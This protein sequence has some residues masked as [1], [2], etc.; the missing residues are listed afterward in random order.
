MERPGFILVHADDGAQ[1]RL[2]ISAIQ[3]YCHNGGDYTSIYLVGDD[4][5]ALDGMLVRET[6]EQLDEILG[7]VRR[8]VSLDVANG[9]GQGVIEGVQQ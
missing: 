9:D 5:I 4:D 6:P 1:I 7:G 2:A 8:Y 3:G